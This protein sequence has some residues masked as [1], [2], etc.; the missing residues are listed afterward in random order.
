MTA[1]AWCADPA[2]VGAVEAV[3]VEAAE[4]GHHVGH[5]G[6]LLI[7]G[8][9]GDGKAVVR[10]H[11]EDR[12]ME[13]ARAVE[14]L[15][16]LPLAAGALSEAHV[17]QLVAV[18]GEA[19]LGPA[20]EVAAGLGR[21]D[22]RDALAAG[23]ARLGDDVERRAAPVVRHLAATA[24]GVLGRPDGLQEDLLGRHAQP[25]HERLI[26]VVREEPV[27]GGAQ[28]AGEGQAECLVA[29]ARDLEEDPALLL[30]ADL[31]VVDGARHAG[32]AEVLDQLVGGKPM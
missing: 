9:H 3:H 11:E 5:R 14:A 1:F 12:Q 6:R 4:A 16:E 31:A 8:G 21:A 2:V 22:G 17:G 10:D 30:H 32:Q 29:G 27:V 18:R 15:P 24:G 13:G 19:E 7:G 28:V 26:P 20:G 25:Q 23:R